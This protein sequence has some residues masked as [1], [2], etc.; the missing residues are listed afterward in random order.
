[1]TNAVEFLG[2]K[3]TVPP[4]NLIAAVNRWNELEPEGQEQVRSRIRAK[5]KEGQEQARVV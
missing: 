3:L 1:M 5:L 2:L 4:E